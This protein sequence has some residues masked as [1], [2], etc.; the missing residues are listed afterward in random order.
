MTTAYRYIKSLPI[1]KQPSKPFWRPFVLL[2]GG[3][4]LL[5]YAF[6]PLVNYQLRTKNRFTRMIISPTRQILAQDIGSEIAIDYSRPANWFP[7]S[8]AITYQPDGVLHYTL[9]IPAL[10]I[11]QAIVEING[12]D[13]KKSLIHYGGTAL[14]GQYGNAVVFGHSS[15]PHFF[16]PKNYQTIFST[17]PEIEKDDEVLINY[18]GISYRY[19][20]K[21]IFEVGPEDLSVIEQDFS[22]RYLSLITCVP[23]G[24]YLRRLV[25]KAVLQ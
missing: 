1:Q 7:V 5:I 25:V 23:P 24:T 11:K 3:I 15:L 13:L 22:G 16:S 20:V 6:W 14:P 21:Q 17:L 18:D 19:R 4:L 12:Q 9:T 2:M 10:R 8:S